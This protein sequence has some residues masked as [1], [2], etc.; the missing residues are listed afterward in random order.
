MGEASHLVTLDAGTVVTMG[1][2][3]AEDLRCRD[4]VFAVGF[5]EVPTT[6]EHHRIRVLRLQVEELLHH[7]GQLPVLL[8]HYYLYTFLLFYLYFLMYCKIIFT[9]SSSLCPSTVR[10]MS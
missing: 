7:R 9:I 5:I 8:R 10:T 4:G 3:D 2:G 1:E 6:E